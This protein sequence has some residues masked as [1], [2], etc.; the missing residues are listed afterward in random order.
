MKRSIIPLGQN[1]LS[2]VLPRAWVKKC[3]L[4][5][6]S[7]VAVRRGAGGGLLIVPAEK[8]DFRY[9]QKFGGSLVVTLPSAWVGERCIDSKMDFLNVTSR[10]EVLLIK[11]ARRQNA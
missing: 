8:T 9:V 11:K 3:E 7:V 4:T 6:Q 5:Q 2:F 1:S 10:G